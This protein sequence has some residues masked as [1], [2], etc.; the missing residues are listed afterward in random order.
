MFTMNF[1]LGAVISHWD[2]LHKYRSGLEIFGDKILKLLELIFILIVDNLKL[3]LWKKKKNYT[4]LS[5][6]KTMC[7]ECYILHIYPI[8][9]FC[10]LCSLFYLIGMFLSGSGFI[11][12][13]PVSAGVG[14]TKSFSS[15]ALFS[16]VFKSGYLLNITFILDRCH[17]S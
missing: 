9:L 2:V 11:Y 10:T 13:E 12:G 17:R 3:E 15:I 6:I 1:V 16:Q 4:W 5:F 8:R 14:V 7:I